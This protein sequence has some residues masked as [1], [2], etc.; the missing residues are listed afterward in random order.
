M[1][2]YSLEHCKGETL[3]NKEW[4]GDAGSSPVAFHRLAEPVFVT[5][6]QHWGVSP[7]PRQDRFGNLL[8]WCCKKGS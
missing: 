2:E 4:G 3:E 5:R 8:V 1:Q 7:S 6:A